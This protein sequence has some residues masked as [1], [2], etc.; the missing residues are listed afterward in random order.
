MRINITHLAQEGFKYGA[1]GF[2]NTDWG[3]YGH[4]QP[5]GLSFT[6]TSLGPSRV[7]MQVKQ[8]RM[9]LNGL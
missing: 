9:S 6:D 4:Y 1:S 2:L 5:L 8:T 7:G 3:D